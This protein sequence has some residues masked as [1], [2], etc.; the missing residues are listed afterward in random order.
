[1]TKKII[2]VIL[3]LLIC[4]SG[5]CLM[6]YPY[7]AAR[8]A[9]SVRSEMQTQYNDIVQEADT[10]QTER[11]LASAQT[12]NTRLFAGEIDIL[13]PE[14]YGYYS[15]LKIPGT[16]IMA[17]VVIP[18]IGV[19]LPI[20]HG[21][22]DAE[23]A[24]GCGHVP[25]TS[26]PVGGTNTH[27]AVSAHTGMASGAMFSD[28]E[29]L[30]PG[31]IFQLKVLGTTLTYEIQSPEDINTVKPHEV[32]LLQIRQGEDLCTLIT[33]TPFGVNS[34]RLLVRG[35]RIANP[36]EEVIQEY[37]AQVSTQKPDS[38]WEANYWGSIKYG[39][40]TAGGILLVF[41]VILAVYR[42]KKAKHE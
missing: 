35:H 41:F 11:I 38:V 26:L 39:L 9:K 12:Y 33:C 17:Y 20:Y 27:C 29:L 5:V 4:T 30:T 36:S 23:L 25:Q 37:I 14:A 34:H 6:L 40:L 18:K 15:E 19:E 42:R 32:E 24:K 7:A 13:D 3:L 28:L 31:D 10:S 2:L 16:E 1:M 22:G 21:I 8:Y